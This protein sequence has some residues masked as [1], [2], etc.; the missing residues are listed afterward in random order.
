MSGDID[1]SLAAS[2]VSPDAVSP[3]TK[4]TLGDYRYAIGGGAG[5]FG[6][7]YG[8]LLKTTVDSNVGNAGASGGYK[9]D[10]KLPKGVRDIIERNIKNGTPENI[11]K[12]LEEIPA[13][14][15]NERWPN[16]MM[17]DVLKTGAKILGSVGLGGAGGG[18]FGGMMGASA[19]QAIAEKLGPVYIRWIVI[20]LGAIIIGIGLYM[21]TQ[22]ATINIASGA[23]DSTAGKTATKLI[24]G[25]KV[26]TLAK[27][28]LS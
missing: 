5:A 10:P 28:V 14:T 8:E 13:G 15:G 2:G 22:K 9:I 11:D 3:K 26:A 16:S 24:P 21:F 20:V 12:E 18:I 1:A 4:A 27:G 19:G 25:G 17:G 7:N 6:P 23:L